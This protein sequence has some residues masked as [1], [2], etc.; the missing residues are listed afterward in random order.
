[1]SGSEFNNFRIYL[2]LLERNMGLFVLLKFGVGR[3]KVNRLEIKIFL[4]KL[5]IF[6]VGDCVFNFFFLGNGRF[7]I[8]NLYFVISIICILRF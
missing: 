4:V 6:R 3:L 1:M 8:D 7:N 5:I 2:G